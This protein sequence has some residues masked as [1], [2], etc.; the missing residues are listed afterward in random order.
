MAAAWI[1]LASGVVAAAISV[2]IAIRQMRADERL[3]HLKS[4]L[5]RDLETMKT[6]LAAELHEREAIIDRDLRAADVLACYREPLAVAAF[7]LQSRLYN[8]LRLDFFGKFGGSH[9]RNEIAL[10]TTLF[11]LAQYFG[12]TEILRREIQFLS[13]PEADHTRRVANLQ[14]QIAK[15]F[16]SDSYGESMMIWSDEQRALGELMIAEE[17]D[18]VLSMGFAAFSN[19]CDSDFKPWLDRLRKELPQ[20]EAQARLRRVQQLLC[21]LVEMLDVNRVRYT[22]D[23]E[24]S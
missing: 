22:E 13:F 3:E 24:R 5:A 16:L 14:S 21:E 23:L 12:W 17:Q 8:I 7:D 10:R 9:A 11:R 18:K 20:E 19:R 1:G 4:D 2:F 6:D 15:A